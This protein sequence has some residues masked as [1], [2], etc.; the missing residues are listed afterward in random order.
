MQKQGGARHWRRVSRVSRCHCRGLNGDSKTNICILMPGTCK[1]DLFSEE[2]SFANVIKDFKVRPSWILSVCVQSLSHVQLFATLWT[3]AHHAP[4]SM[5]FSRQEYWSGL[6]FPL[7]P[8][9]SLVRERRGGFGIE[10]HREEGRVNMKAE[11]SD[12]STSQGTPGATGS[13]ERP[14][15]IL[16]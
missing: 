11:T 6:P 1:C 10:T 8:M 16:P 4:L 3:V 2:R 15:R 7:N 14:G 12:A 9:T 5:E 13:W